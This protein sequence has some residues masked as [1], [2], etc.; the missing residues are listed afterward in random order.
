MLRRAC[1]QLAQLGRSYGIRISVNISPKQFRESGFVERL[2]RVL[3]ETGA[4][5][6]LLTLEITE[7]LVIDNIEQTIERMRTLK[8]LGISF[9]LDD[10]GTGHSSLAYLKRLPLDAIKIDQSFVRDITTDPND[11]VIV[12]TII[13]MSQHLGLQAVAEGVESD[14]ALQFLQRKGCRQFQ[15]YLFGRP[16]P[17]EQLQLRLHKW[18][19]AYA[20]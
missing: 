12:E 11:A 14:E 10:F 5:P 2:Q 17:F 15:G 9:S 16:E 19:Q 20:S 3:E 8:S 6:E 7:S 18:L 13:V 4:P 1:E